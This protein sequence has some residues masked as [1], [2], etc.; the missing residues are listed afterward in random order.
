MLFGTYSA[1]AMPP[2]ATRDDLPQECNARFALL[3]TA[4]NPVTG[5]ERTKLDRS[6]RG[7]CDELSKAEDWE[8]R[9]RRLQAG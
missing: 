2:S 3:Y 1:E 8:A 7:L 6:A 5:S 9:H 4:T